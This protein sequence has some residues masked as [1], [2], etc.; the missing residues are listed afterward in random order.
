MG[1]V[2]SRAMRRLE[3][4]VGR[5][6]SAARAA[7]FRRRTAS[8]AK[9]YRLH[10][11]CGSVHLSGWVNVDAERPG[12]A[13]VV[14]DAT[15]RFPLPD[16]SCSRIFNEHFLKH[17]PVEQGVAFLRECHRLLQSEGDPPIGGG[18]TAGKGTMP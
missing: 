5:R 16:A 8:L 12:A 18:A 15:R 7:A 17:L 10:I 2:A 6:R 14:W 4:A 9:P 11:G 3:D 13:D 1:G